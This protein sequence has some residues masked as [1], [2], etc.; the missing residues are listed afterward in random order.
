MSK[1]PLR[2]TLLAF[3]A[4]NA[5][6]LFGQSGQIESW[7]TNPDRSALFKKQPGSFEINITNP[8]K[9]LILRTTQNRSRNVILWNL[10]ADPLNDPHT[11]TPIVFMN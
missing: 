8:V 5:S 11:E 4:L 3:A 1:I 7:I 10:A 9:N 6:L 2:I